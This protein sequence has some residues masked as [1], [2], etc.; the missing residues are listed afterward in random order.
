MPLRQCLTHASFRELL[1]STKEIAMNIKSKMAACVLSFAAMTSTFSTANAQMENDQ[2]QTCLSNSLLS[3]FNCSWR[4][5]YFTAEALY[6]KACRDDNGYGLKERIYIP[7]G[8]ISIKEKQP[9]LR[10]DWGYR[11]GVGYNLPDDC[12]NFYASWTH[13]NTKRHS[14]IDSVAPNRVGTII[15]AEA[16][17]TIAPD[18]YPA[19]LRNKN[20]LYTDWADF[21]FGKRICFGDTFTFRP[22]VGARVLWFHQRNRT[23]IFGEQVIPT[24]PPV[25]GITER[26]RRFDHY[27][28][29]GIRAGFDTYWGLGCGFTVVGS[30]AG[31]ILGGKDSNHI[32]DFFRFVNPV[33]G[34]VVQSVTTKVKG[35]NCSGKAMLDLAVALRWDYLLMNAYFVNLQ[36]GYEQHT[37]FNLGRQ[38]LNG[39]RSHSDLTFHGI[40]FGGTVR[41]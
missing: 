18:L 21:E 38:S 30:A 36:V 29:A 35:R 22:H 8:T 37:L 1:I 24:V 33:T 41:F 3:G 23:N 20:H 16:I 12:W 34:A 2:G 31:S 39:R 19:R 6:W 32:K 15:L 7:R 9:H 10:W 25:S 17:D 26:V 14:H 28:G 11:F 5:F 13:F 40:N 4:D 27:T